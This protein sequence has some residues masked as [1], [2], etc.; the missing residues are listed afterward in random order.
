MEINTSI[1][2]MGNCWDKTNQIVI[3][4]PCLQNVHPPIVLGTLLLYI[5]R[6]NDKA[7]ETRIFT[8]LRKL[9]EI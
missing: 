9:Y 1:I 2:I 7:S 6:G 3:R 4:A 8:T 5:P